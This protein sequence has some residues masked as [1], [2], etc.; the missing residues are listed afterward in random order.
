MKI[1]T[2]PLLRSLPNKS[3]DP[4]VRS[5]N[6][7]GKSILKSVRRPTNRDEAWKHNDMKRLFGSIRLPLHNTERNDAEV[8]LSLTLTL[9]LGWGRC[10]ELTLTLTLNLGWGRK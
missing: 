3:Q 7:K 4:L 10:G 2:P 9:K 5:I 6:E 8:T 1:M